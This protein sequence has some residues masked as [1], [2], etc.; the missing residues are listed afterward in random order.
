MSKTVTLNIRDEVN[1]RFDGIDAADRRALV[2]MFEY[3]VPGARYLPSVRL[4][5][6]NGK[7]SYFTLAGSSYLNLLDQ[8]IHYLVDKGYDLELNDVREYSTNFQFNEVDENSF[9]HKL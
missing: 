2:K 3:E 6:W 8:I 4:S 7:V 1:V 5:R 9:S